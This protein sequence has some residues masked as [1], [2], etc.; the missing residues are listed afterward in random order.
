MKRTI[1][2]IRHAKSDWG[3]SE[4]SDF[5]RPLNRRG[6]HD[7]PA[8]GRTLKERLIT[9]DLILA[10]PAIRALTTVHAI[11]RE[12]E[13][14]PDKIDFR[15]DLYL[16]PASD[17]MDL[18][19]GIDDHCQNIAIVGHNPG[20]TTLANILGDRQIDNMPTC[21]IIRLET[22]ILSWQEL[23]RASATT[24]DFLYPE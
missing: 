12:I 19:Q 9:F 14:N 5:D 4:L 2:L 10:S 17:M 3:N 7:A 6:N 21:S 22:D 24:I 13:Y 15:P 20:L 1:T 8:M 18:I 23:K 16:A 11:C